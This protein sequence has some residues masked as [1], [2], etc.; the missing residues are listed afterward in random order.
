LG[1]EEL[2][3][4]GSGEAEPSPKRS[5]EVELIP[6]GSGKAEPSPEVDVL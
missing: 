2:V 6:E 5:G 3:P 4:E 1:E